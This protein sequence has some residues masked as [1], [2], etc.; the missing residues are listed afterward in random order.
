ML[1][2]SG[3]SNNRTNAAIANKHTIFQ[4][5]GT[6]ELRQ[7]ESSG[8][9]TDRTGGKIKAGTQSG[10]GN[11]H[12][13]PFHQQLGDSSVQADIYADK[14]RIPRNRDT[15]YLS[16]NRDKVVAKVAPASSS[17]FLSRDRGDQPDRRDQCRYCVNKEYQFP[18]T[19]ERG[20][21]PGNDRAEERGNRLDKLPQSQDTRNTVR[22]NHISHHRIQGETCKIVL[23]I[24]NKAKASRIQAKS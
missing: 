22:T 15:I 23:P 24:P 3:T 7:Q 21:R 17:F 18:V 8:K 13:C 9:R 12:A 5:A 1:H 20:S 10:F 16:L 4:E 11:G 6:G 14:K 19:P 2:I